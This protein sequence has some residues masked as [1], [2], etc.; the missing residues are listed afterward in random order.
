VG[1]TRRSRRQASSAASSLVSAAGLTVPLGNR[2]K[3]SPNWRGRTEMRQQ[4][5]SIDN[6]VVFD[7]REDVTGNAAIAHD[8][9]ATR[10]QHEHSEAVLWRGGQ[11]GIFNQVDNVFFRN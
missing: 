9:I 10:V 1:T 5:R 4:R 6:A 8:F 2:R 3:R 11:F 7:K